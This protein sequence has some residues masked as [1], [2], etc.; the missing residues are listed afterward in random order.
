M[1]DCETRRFYLGYPFIAG[2]TL[3]PSPIFC[4]SSQIL[5]FAEPQLLIL[6]HLDRTITQNDLVCH[7]QE[8]D[9]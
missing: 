3:R 5:P 7:E 6:C 2:T 4:S 9:T 8:V 1:A